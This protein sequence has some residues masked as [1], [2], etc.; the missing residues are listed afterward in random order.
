MIVLLIISILV[1]FLVE[2]WSIRHGLDRI[3]YDL[4]LSQLLLEPDEEFTIRS[5]IENHKFWFV[6]Y[7]NMVEN[8]PSGIQIPGEEE[9]LSTGTVSP[10]LYA[11]TSDTSLQ[12]LASSQLTTS[13]YLMPRQRLTRTLRA[14]LPKRG[15]YLFL[16]C[17]IS[18]GDLLG[19]QDDYRTLS[20]FKEVV[21]MPR[22]VSSPSF[23][24]LLGG[25]MGDISVNRFIFEDPMLTIGFSDYTGRE[26]LRD[27]SWTQSARLG[28]MMVKN[29]DHTIDLSV[30]IILN[31]QSVLNVFE[32]DDRL[33]ACCSIARSVCEQLEAKHIQYSF[34]SNA[35][36]S[37]TTS[38]YTDIEQGLGSGHFYGV[39]EFLG[40]VTQG[41][42]ESFSFT[43]QRACRNCEPGRHHIVITPSRNPAWQDE[44]HRLQEL[45]DGRVFLLTPDDLQ[46]QTDSNKEGKTA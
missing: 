11:G 20:L 13:F 23:D 25:M 10:H 1:L 5:T 31:I 44:L 36:P 45:S 6:P 30:T 14:Q 41:A 16:G 12:E 7:V 18:G 2:R 28:R 9:S 15:R 40:R 8:F 17:R 19:L 4:S 35:I 33:E 37:G 29:Y 34:L 3:V 24:L 21:V 32:E 39:M 43:L 38:L 27:I 42:L 26:P 22:R 46:E